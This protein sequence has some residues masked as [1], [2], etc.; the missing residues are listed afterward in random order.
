MIIKYIESTVCFPIV[1][2]IGRGI[3]G[4]DSESLFTS[5][6]SSTKEESCFYN[7]DSTLMGNLGN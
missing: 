2:F 7:A 6:D 4:A 3:E 1:S 5:G